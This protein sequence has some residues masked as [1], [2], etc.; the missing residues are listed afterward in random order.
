MKKVT[1]NFESE[2]YRPILVSQI[3]GKAEGPELP[4]AG[5][6]LQRLSSPNPISL[7]EGSPK[8]LNTEV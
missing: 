6:Q 1:V 2:V 4:S 3:N 8:H 5:R 7:G